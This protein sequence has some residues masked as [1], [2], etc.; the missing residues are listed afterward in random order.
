MKYPD[1]EDLAAAGLS[2][3][4]RDPLAKSTPHRAKAL[5]VARRT[6]WLAAAKGYLNLVDAGCDDAAHD[7]REA[8]DEA[9]R[10]TPQTKKGT[11]K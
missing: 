5:F 6:F 4:N 10:Y 7:A 3:P 2:F 9:N 8:L 1:L 11:N